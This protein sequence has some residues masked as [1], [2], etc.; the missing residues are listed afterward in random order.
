MAIAIAASIIYTRSDNRTPTQADH[1]PGGSVPKEPA[2]N[3][4]VPAPNQVGG[5]VVRDRQRNDPENQVVKYRG[6]AGNKSTKGRAATG[7]ERTES[8]EIATDYF[9][10]DF[11]SYLQPLDGGRVLRIKLPRSALMNYGLPVDPLRAD[12]A[13]KADVV[14]GDDGMARAIRFVR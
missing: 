3:R 13:V 12:E 2:P 6:P 7:R 5:T 1:Q 8:Y 4:D 10:I 9:P 11:G 14:I